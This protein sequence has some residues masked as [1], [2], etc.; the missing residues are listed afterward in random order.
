MFT[1]TSTSLFVEMTSGLKM[2]NKSHGTEVR[3]GKKVQIQKRL[4]KVK[5]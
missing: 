3:K 4:V 5:I 2:K 1:K